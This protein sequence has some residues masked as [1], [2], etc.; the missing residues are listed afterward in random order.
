MSLDLTFMAV[1]RTVVFD[2]NMTHNLTQMASEAGI[3]NCLWRPEETGFKTA[4]QM[5]E[6]L[7]K[8]LALLES[9]PQRFKPFSAPN[10]WGTYDQFVPW[11]RE[12]LEAARENPDAEVESS[13]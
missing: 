8:G 11:V 3:Y 6:P 10:G 7:E 5:I 4:S 13:R 9:D 2:T 12:V 1:R